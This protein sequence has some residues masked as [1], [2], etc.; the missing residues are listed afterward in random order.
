MP[1][2]VA[3]LGLGAC[4]MLLFHRMIRPIVEDELSNIK[5]DANIY[6]STRVLSTGTRGI[7]LEGQGMIMNYGVSTLFVYS[8]MSCFHYLPELGNF[9][10]SRFL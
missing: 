8:A 9:L 2:D 1:Y 5:D 3:Y 7:L 6:T 10:T 4:E